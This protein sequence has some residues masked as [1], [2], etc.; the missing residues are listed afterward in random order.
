[1][2]I[3]T[4]GSRVLETRELNQEDR[5]CPWLLQVYYLVKAEANQ[6]LSWAGPNSG[7]EQI[8]TVLQG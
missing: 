6:Q 7:L 3:N 5:C 2:E 1:M 8:L 4:C